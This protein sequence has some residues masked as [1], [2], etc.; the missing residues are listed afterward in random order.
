MQYVNQ[1]FFR[2]ILSHKLQRTTSFFVIAPKISF[3]SLECKF[4][5]Y[6]NRK[7]SKL[8]GLICLPLKLCTS[9]KDDFFVRL[10]DLNNESD[11]PDEGEQDFD[12]DDVIIHENY[13][14][15]PSP[16]RDIALVKLKRKHGKC[17]KFVII[18]FVN[19]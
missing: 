15:Y 4:K 18:F 11:E 5:C 9:D 8:I 19:F 7:I 17:A 13:E 12:I 3:Q 2:K 14:A 1:F 16:R 6:C 10:G